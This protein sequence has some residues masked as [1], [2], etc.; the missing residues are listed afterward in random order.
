MLYLHCKYTVM[1]SVQYFAYCILPHSRK[2]S[3]FCSYSQK[4]SPQNLGAWCNL[5][6]PLASNPRKFFPLVCKSP[7]KFLSKL[8]CMMEGT[9]NT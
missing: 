7:R 5:V 4:F 2:L 3:R 1:Y 6:A 8:L 9:E